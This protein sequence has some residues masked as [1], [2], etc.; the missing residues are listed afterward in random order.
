[1]PQENGN[2]SDVRWAA[3]MDEDKLGL[4]VSGSSPFNVSVH[5]YTVENLTAAKHTYEVKSHDA[6][7]WNLDYQLMGLG[8][9][10]SWNPRTHKEYLLK[11][12]TY[13]YRIKL[14]PI[15]S[16]LEKAV[17]DSKLELPEFSK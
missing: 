8:G 12:G 4:L 16:G 5:D 10:D 13:K 3:L 1:M 11:P 17:S 15:Y 14:S 9:D 7:T 6:I 2:K